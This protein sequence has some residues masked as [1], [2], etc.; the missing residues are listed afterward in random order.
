MCRLIYHY[1]LPV[2]SIIITFIAIEFKFADIN[3]FLGPT[4]THFS[5]SWQASSLSRKRLLECHMQG[6]LR[7][8]PKDSCVTDYMARV[9][10][11]TENG[12]KH[13]YALKT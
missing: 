12:P 4:Q 8:T 2:I 1:S 13:V 9:K 5:P 6:A 11:G 7:N 10:N 3:M